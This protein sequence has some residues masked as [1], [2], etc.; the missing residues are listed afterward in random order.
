MQDWAVGSGGPVGRILGSSFVQHS[1]DVSHDDGSGLICEEIVGVI[2]ELKGAND[3]AV[4]WHEAPSVIQSLQHLLHDEKR[5]VKGKREDMAKKEGSEGD[6]RLKWFA[7]RLAELDQYEKVGAFFGLKPVPVHWVV[8][9]VDA[10]IR[11][12]NVLGLG[13]VRL[14]V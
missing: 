5:A 2:R 14:M 3:D 1:L 4:Q 9:G 11:D 6:F 10:L 12:M 13:C 8:A 7:D